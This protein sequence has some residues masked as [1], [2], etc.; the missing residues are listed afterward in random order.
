MDKN[1]TKEINVNVIFEN[2]Y[3]LVEQDSG[4]VILDSG[5]PISF[6]E[7]GCIVFGEESLSCDTSCSFVDNSLLTEKVGRRIIGIMGT[8]LM[9]RFDHL[10]FFLRENGESH[11]F[12]NGCH[13]D[14]DLNSMNIMG[15]GTADLEINGQIHTVFVDTGAVTS[16]IHSSFVEGMEPC[17]EVGD[18]HPSYGDFT[19]KLYEMN[20]VA[21][22]HTYPVK[23]GTLPGM[24][25]MALK[26]VGVDG[27]VGT[28]FL[29]QH[30]FIWSKGRWFIQNGI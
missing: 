5:S 16:Y 9:N 17:G 28:D 7:N 8:D 14:G 1:N 30:I 4:F 11:I 22:K 12:I 19:T 10:V 26:M 24:A 13:H 20:I 29:K 15:V 23:F 25:E 18:F 6:C 27:I 21:F 2:G 3:V